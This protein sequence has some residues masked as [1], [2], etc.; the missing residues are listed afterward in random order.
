MSI[1]AF[2]Q[3]PRVI[4]LGDHEGL[5]YVYLPSLGHLCE[6]GNALGEVSEL[7]DRLVEILLVFYWV[8]RLEPR[9]NSIIDWIPGTLEEQGLSS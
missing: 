2:L 6:F 9:V 3:L 7:T 5:L 4:A 8:R 1:E